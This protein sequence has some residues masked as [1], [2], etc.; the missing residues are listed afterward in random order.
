VRWLS[1]VDVRRSV[2]GLPALAVLRRLE[3]AA[4]A[5]PGPHAP[6]GRIASEA[7]ARV[8][9]K[10]TDAQTAHFLQWMERDVS[11]PARRLRARAAGDR[12]T[13]D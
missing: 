11:G 2:P 10:A 1:I 9:A 3:P 12:S 4:C 7:L 6:E 5:D 8:L 13:T